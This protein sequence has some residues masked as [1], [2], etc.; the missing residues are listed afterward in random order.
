M[1]DPGS[2]L[3]KPRR[4]YGR[5]PYELGVNDIDLR[6]SGV[7]LRDVVDLAFKNTGIPR[8]EFEV[9]KWAKDVYGKSHPVEW[10]APNG[11]EVSIDFAHQTAGPDA[12]HVGWQTGG[13]RSQGAARGH[14]ILDEVPYGRTGSYNE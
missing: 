5:E 8:E 12:P 2:S 4:W 7:S 11:A 14:I 9:T 6:G 1:D 13:K 3:R 10:R